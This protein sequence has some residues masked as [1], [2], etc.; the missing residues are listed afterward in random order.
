MPP[1][2]FL[3]ISRPTPEEVRNNL[4]MIACQMLAG[5]CKTAVAEVMDGGRLWVVIAKTDFRSFPV[6]PHFTGILFKGNG[7]IQREGG[8][9][10]L[11]FEASFLVDPRYMKKKMLE[12]SMDDPDGFLSEFREHFDWSGISSE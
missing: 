4:I 3:T 6:G 10:L 8:K 9:I 2:S 12:A 7:G 11:P 1:F 5:N